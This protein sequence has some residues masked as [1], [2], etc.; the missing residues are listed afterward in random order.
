MVSTRTSSRLRGSDY[1]EGGRAMHLKPKEPEVSVFFRISVWSI[2]FKLFKTLC[3]I[4]QIL[5]FIIV[6]V[7]KM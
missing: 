5:K 2:P 7:K 6:I 3:F 1:L 4:F